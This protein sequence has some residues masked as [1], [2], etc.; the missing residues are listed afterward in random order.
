MLRRRDVLPVLFGF[1][2]AAGPAM[3]DTPRRRAT[4]RRA[5]APRPQTP[6]RMDID[7]PRSR[8]AAPLPAR[9]IQPPL[10]DR[11]AR[12]SV[13]FGVPT[14][15]EFG[16]SQTLDQGDAALEA[17][18]REAAPLSDYRPSIGATVRLPF[19]GPAR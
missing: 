14:R 3:A 10:A 19:G 16:G 17:R 1:A 7:L 9:N 8:D 4:V 12:Q 15:R 6:A 2:L 5:P 18:A 11:Q 13:E